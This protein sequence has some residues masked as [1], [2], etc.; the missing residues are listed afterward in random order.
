MQGQCLCCL[1]SF[2]F[3]PG[4]WGGSKA[5]THQQVPFSSFLPP[6][7]SAHPSTFPSSVLHSFSCCFLS[8]SSCYLFISLLVLW[9]LA[10][11][12]QRP[13]FS[14]LLLYSVFDF[15]HMSTLSHLITFYLIL[16]QQISHTYTICIFPSICLSLLITVFRRVLEKWEGEGRRGGEQGGNK[17]PQSQRD[18]LSLSGFNLLIRSSRTHHALHLNNT[19]YPL[20]H[21]SHPQFCLSPSISGFNSA[22]HSKTTEDNRWKLGLGLQPFCHIVSVLFIKSDSW[23]KIVGN[24]LWRTLA[25]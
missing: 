11:R 16:S 2:S 24:T 8:F 25:P 12:S 15:P 10:F 18:S 20:L 3:S 22:S 6:L 1:F 19:S 5:L 13:S 21:P 7:A 23:E 9:P 4:E 14:S 17:A